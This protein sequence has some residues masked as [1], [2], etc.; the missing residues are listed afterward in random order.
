MKHRL[1]LCYRTWGIIYI[2]LLVLCTRMFADYRYISRN[3][4]KETTV[5]AAGIILFAEHAH[6]DIMALMIARNHQRESDIS[7]SRWQFNLTSSR[8]LTTSQRAVQIFAG[9]AGSQTSPCFIASFWFAEQVLL[10]RNDQYL[11]CSLL[12]LRHMIL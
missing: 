10:R 8:H 4:L 5:V 1:R 7:Q 9:L 12:N 6:T 11:K 2:L 3:T